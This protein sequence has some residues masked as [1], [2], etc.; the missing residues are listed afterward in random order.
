V[1]TK[2][3]RQH[4]EVPMNDSTSPVSFPLLARGVTHD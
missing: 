2:P 3:S 1:A 4:K